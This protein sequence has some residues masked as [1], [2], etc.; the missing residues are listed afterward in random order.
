MNSDEIDERTNIIRQVSKAYKS[1]PS[2]GLCELV[3]KRHSEAIRMKYQRDEAR[4][5]ALGL[6]IY[7]VG[8]IW[9]WL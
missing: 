2:D 3:V 8:H 5:I 7:I 1:K 9:G 6:L 4:I